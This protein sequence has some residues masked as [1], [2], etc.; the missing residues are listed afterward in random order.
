MPCAEAWKRSVAPVSTG[1]AQQQRNIG[2]QRKVVG[3]LDKRRLANRSRLPRGDWTAIHSIC[4]AR[5]RQ[6]AATSSKALLTDLAP[7]AAWRRPPSV[8]R[9]PPARTT[10]EDYK[11][12]TGGSGV[13]TQARVRDFLVKKRQMRAPCCA[14]TTLGP[15]PATNP[16][17]SIFRP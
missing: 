2:R 12:N 5:T 1:S 11:A 8:E 4:S 9:H 13:L 10:G 6:P 7:R 16:L 17:I 14:C 15:E 3:R